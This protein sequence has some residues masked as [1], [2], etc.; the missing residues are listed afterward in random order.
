MHTFFSFAHSIKD[1]TPEGCCILNPNYC[2][3]WRDFKF[4]ISLNALAN[5]WCSEA[6]SM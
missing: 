1:L 6:R 5:V 4:I 3:G 2:P